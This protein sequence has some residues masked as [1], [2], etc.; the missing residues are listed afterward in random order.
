MKHISLAILAFFLVLGSFS[1]SASAPPKPKTITLDTWGTA[2]ALYQ[3]DTLAAN[4]MMDKFREVKIRVIPR[5]GEIEGM[6]LLQSRRSD[7]SNYSSGP[8]LIQE[9]LEDFAKQEW[10]P[11]QIQTVNV[12]RHP[13]YMMAVRGD[14]D[15]YKLSDL[16][17]KRVAW[18]PG[19][20]AR[21][22]STEAYLAFANL[23]W[24]NVVK[25]N[26]SNT[27]EAM[28]GVLNGITDVALINVSGSYMYEWASKPYGIRYLQAPLSDKEGWKRL[29]DVSPTYIPNIARKG[30]GISL[31]KPVEGYGAP[32]TWVALEST[33]ES[34]SYWVA[35]ML[36][37]ALP[38]YSQQNEWMQELWKPEDFWFCWENGVLPMHPGAVLYYKEIGEWNP[39]RQALQDERMN[40]QRQLKEAWDELLSEAA[41]KNFKPADF[42]N[43]WTEKRKQKGLAQA[44]EL[45]SQ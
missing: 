9:G 20:P 44:G 17:G 30:A 13:G 15:I 32:P 19:A 14:S 21:N 27:N 11:Q 42:P 12:N 25:V 7:I 29:R 1:H 24:D 4:G 23:S 41:E 8:S 39:M 45:K 22:Q 10:G 5:G 26:V 37:E 40:R 35:R 28:R 34:I 6:I 18:Q 43:A 3:Q 2:T 33:D 31:E 16:K 36:R 38:I